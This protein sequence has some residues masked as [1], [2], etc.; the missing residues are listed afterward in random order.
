MSRNRKTPKNAGNPKIRK[1]RSA[2][3]RESSEGFTGLEAAI[4]LLAF[5]VV[6][7]AFSYVVLG[8]GFHTVQKSQAVIYSALEQSSSS[9][10]VD[11]VMYIRN[12]TTGNIGMIRIYMRSPHSLVPADLSKMTISFA[13]PE[14]YCTIEQD[15]PLYD[16][17]NPPAAGKWNIYRNTGSDAGKDAILLYN[18]DY[19]II[20]VH[21]PADRELEPGDEYWIEVVQPLGLSMFISRT[22]PAQ[23]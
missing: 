1:D 4:V 18:G 15:S 8:S 10:L 21:L 13:T 16:N 7:A 2:G 12:T 22:V 20:L 6:T 9:I 23:P 3:G 5:V 17:G 11:E 14:G 19:A